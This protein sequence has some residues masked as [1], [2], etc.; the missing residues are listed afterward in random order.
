MT[1]QSLCVLSVHLFVRVISNQSASNSH[2]ICAK[3]FS[4]LD[5]LSHDA[6][7][8]GTE[9]SNIG[10]STLNRGVRNTVPAMSS[11]HKLQTLLCYLK[12]VRTS[13]K[14]YRYK[15][16]VWRL[17]SVLQC[18]IVSKK[19]SRWPKK[20]YQKKINLNVTLNMVNNLLFKNE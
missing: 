2:V 3:P 16:R 4:N 6:C 20:V 8:S 17:F 13:K 14:T 19:V 1:V 15:Q 7:A 5:T 12:K 11:Q 9:I 10:W 18:A